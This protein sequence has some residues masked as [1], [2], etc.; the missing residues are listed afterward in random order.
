[1]LSHWRGKGGAGGAS[2]QADN[3]V[4]KDQYL[5]TKV[6]KVRFSENKGIGYITTQ[7]SPVGKDPTDATPPIGKII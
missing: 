6:A 7:G 2:Q 1:M 4:G 3:A 5:E